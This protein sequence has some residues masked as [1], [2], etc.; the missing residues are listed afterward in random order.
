MLHAGTTDL[1]AEHAMERKSSWGVTSRNFANSAGGYTMW[2]SFFTVALV[3][4]LGLGTAS[5]IIET[6][7]KAPRPLARRR[8][9]G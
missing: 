7:T 2:I 6:N 8:I 3:I 1:S 5:L 4:A 9:R